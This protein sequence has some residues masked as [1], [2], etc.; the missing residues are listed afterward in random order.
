MNNKLFRPKS[1]ER[2]S[3]PEQ[4]NEYI[5][6]SNP[7]VWMLLGAIVILLLGVCVWGV[8]GHLDTTLAVVAVGQDDAVIAYVKEADAGMLRTGM[9]VS[10]GENKGSVAEI[11]AQPVQAQDVLSAYMLHVGAL[12]ADEW[13]YAAQL[14]VEC[15]AGVHE[16]QIVT[17]RVSPMSFVLN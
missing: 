16:A 2:I 6:V 9:E 10:I 13:V 14:D 7:S 5:R 8:T 4:L 1:V 11:A 17:Q 12:Q 3:S 15:A